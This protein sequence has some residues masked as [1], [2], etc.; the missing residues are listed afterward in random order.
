MTTLRATAQGQSEVGE[1]PVGDRLSQAEEALDD[2]PRLTT[3]Q[4]YDDGLVSLQV[5]PPVS[6]GCRHVALVLGVLLRHVVRFGHL[7]RGNTVQ[8]VSAC[9]SY[10]VSVVMEPLQQRE[11]ELVRVLLI[12]SSE[13]RLGPSYPGLEV[14]STDRLVLR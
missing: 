7:V 10:L 3:E 8:Q 13:L 2:R 4:L 5:V 14:A 11:E 1:L 9:Q 12:P 6:P